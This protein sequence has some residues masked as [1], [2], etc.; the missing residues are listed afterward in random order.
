[1]LAFGPAL[2]GGLPVPQLARDGTTPATPTAAGMR[3]MVNG[4]AD[5][6]LF[7]DPWLDYI[8]LV[9]W[10]VAGFALLRWQLGR[11]EA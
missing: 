6:A 1:M 5:R 8:V 2:G 4:V 3:L 7:A 10:G 9:V 11:R